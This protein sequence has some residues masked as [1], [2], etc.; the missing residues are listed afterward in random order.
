MKALISNIEPRQTGYR[1][2]QVEAQEFAVADGMFWID[3]PDDLKAD[4]KWYDPVTQSFQD[5]PPLPPA[6]SCTPLQ[7][8]ERFT[9]AEQ[10]AIVTA[11]LN[12]AAVKL[13]YDKLMAASE[14]VFADPRLSAGMDALVTAGLI[15][16]SR[17]KEI[18]PLNVRSTGLQSL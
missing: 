6:T 15:T 9:E 10:L 8:V 1:V 16:Q 3:C 4:S 13:W 14:V 18:L 17:S 12:N 5:F 11:T 7:F 2:A